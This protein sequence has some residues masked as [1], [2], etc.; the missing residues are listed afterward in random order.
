MARDELPDPLVK[1]DLLHSEKETDFAKYG[2]AFFKAGRYN[3][4]IDFYAGGKLKEGLLKVKRVAV[5][6]GDY[7]L[8]KRIKRVIPEEVTEADWEELAKRATTAG[9][10]NFANWAN[11]E[12]GKRGANGGHEGEEP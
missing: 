3:D 8:L 2:D 6:E 7:F 11:E 10:A 12:W 5:E 4:A 1:R 9:K